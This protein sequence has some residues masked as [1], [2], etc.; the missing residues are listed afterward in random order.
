MFYC[1]IVLSTLALPSALLP[2]GPVI[3][4]DFQRIGI[5]SK[6][7]VLCTDFRLNTLN[8]A[9]LQPAMNCRPRVVLIA[10][11][12]DFNFIFTFCLRNRLRVYD[13]AC[14]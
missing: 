11:F 6:V 13:I 7:S 12:L 14:D 4:S 9:G 8:I 2:A 1:L 10:A 5:G 3:Q